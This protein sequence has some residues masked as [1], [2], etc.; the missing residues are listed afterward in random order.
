M[1]RWLTNTETQ[2]ALPLST[3]RMLLSPSSGEVVKQP[4][5]RGLADP[6]TR[7]AFLREANE[8]RLDAARHR[9]GI[10]LFYFAGHGVRRGT[11]GAILLLEDFGDGV[12]GE[13]DNAI[14]S[15][16]LFDGMA[17]SNK[18]PEVARTQFYF[19]D[20]CQVVPEE[21]K[22]FAVMNA[23]APFDTPWPTKDDRTAPIFNAAALGTS[24]YGLKGEDTLFSRA[25]MKALAGGAGEPFEEQGVP[26]WRVSIT[27]LSSALAVY[28][29]TEGKVAG[30]E[31]IFNTGG[32]WGGVDTA[33]AYLSSTPSV[34][35]VLE[36]TPT[37][38]VKRASLKATDGD[39][40]RYPLPV[41]LKPHP[42]PVVWPAGYYTLEIRYDP[43]GVDKVIPTFAVI[44]PRRR[45]VI[46][47]P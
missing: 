32:V 26:R 45:K 11:E 36:L 20:A 40:N 37:D 35:V 2:L 6:A 16:S 38:A 7:T 19:I 1:F 29:T 13:L 42:Y 15:K 18:Y 31:Q 12:G 25:L 34:D 8:W 41:P 27:S 28:L 23:T 21:A 9:D 3:C 30:V 5:L 33:I 43:P 39:G 14:A 47:W 10:A 46:P 17:P 4:K 44:P 22:E 24:A